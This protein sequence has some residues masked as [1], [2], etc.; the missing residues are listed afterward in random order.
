VC[1]KLIETQ[2]WTL[3]EGH[4]YVDEAQSGAVFDRPGLLRMMDAVKAKPRPFDVLVMYAED[5]L[6]R[7]VVET[8]YLAKQIIDSGVRIFFA[9]GTERKLDSATDALLMAISNFGAAFERERASVRTRDKMRSKAEAGHNTGTVPFGYTSISV[10][11]HKELAVDQAQAEVVRRIFSL[12]AEGNGITRTA[13]ALGHEYPGLRKWSAPTIRDMLHNE[14]YHGVIVYGKTRATVKHGKD[15]KAQ[16]PESAWV[17]L[18]RP[19][20]QI[21]P[22]QL[23][24]AV[25]QRQEAVFSTY[26]RGKKGQLQ[27]R[28][29]SSISNHLLAGFVV[30]GACGGR[31]VVWS[32]GAR[33]RHRYLVCWRH[34]SGGDGACSNKRHVPLEPLTEMIVS[35]FRDDVLTPA[36][37]AQV[38]K[39]LE[40]DAEAS[41]ERASERR[42]NLEAELKQLGQRIDRL[43]NAIVDGGEI[44]SLR[45]A[46]T[47]AEVAQQSTMARLDQLAGTQRIMAQ[48]ATSGQ[49]QRVEVLL[50]DWQAALQGAP[51]VAR[52]ILRKLL[53]G[54]I[55]VT[56]QPDGSFAYEAQGTYTRA[57]AGCLGGK[58]EGE[59]VMMRS[60][61][62]EAED[63]LQAELRA[64]VKALPSPDVGCGPT[65]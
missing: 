62:V 36:R 59:R 13:H 18:E 2:G 63:D 17:R 29:D 57:I 44:K 51:V 22:D 5:R 52:Q 47:S 35:H 21:V 23:W 28:P 14:V 64:L 65:S 58:G 6:G 26:L 45:E 9:D 32:A 10:S 55:V 34:R 24:N 15:K 7:D 56:P 49:Q 46:L 12:S 40:V 38:A 31:M 60:M 4:E 50:S 19:E 11:G 33:S 1:V 37:I 25:K 41:P 8:G 20:L 30:C 39:D 53:V 48:W 42:E 27:G 16:V 43:V 3:A 61:H 54:S